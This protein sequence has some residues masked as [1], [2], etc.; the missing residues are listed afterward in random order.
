MAQ[1]QYSDLDFF[2]VGQLLNARKH[3]VT[4]AQ[5]TT[6]GGSLDTD[7]IGVFVWDTDDNRG[8]TWDGTQWVPEAI[9]VAG[10]VI[11]KGAFDASIALDDGGQPQTIEAVAGYRYV[12]TTAGTFDAGSSGVTLDGNQNLD[13]GDWILFTSTT[14]AYAIQTN[15]SYSTTTVAGIIQ[16]ATE[17]EVL[18]GTEGTKAVTPDT[19]QA[20][21][22]QQGYTRGYF[23]VVSTTLLTPLNINHGLGLVDKDAFTINI[24]NSAGS[25]VEAD[26]DSV[27]ADNLT[28]TTF[29]SVSD[30]HVTITGLPAA[31]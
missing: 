18:T 21:L 31:S 10:D 4:G 26:V 13:V 24:M 25:Q 30:L 29:L 8:Y 14:E 1:G 11:L 20:K 27:D 15:V 19:L 28:I 6:L 9:E 12:V 16:L 7:H 5:R 22:D 3:N 2:T 17:A 23:E